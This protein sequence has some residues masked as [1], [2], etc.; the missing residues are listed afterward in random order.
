M[1][2]SEIYPGQRLTVD[3]DDDGREEKV[4]VY[5]ITSTSLICKDRDNALF[6]ISASEVQ[7]VVV[8]TW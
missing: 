5:R 7:N 1:R 6:A 2:F 4:E 3:L 8:G